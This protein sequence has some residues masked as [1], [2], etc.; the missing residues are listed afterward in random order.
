MPSQAL[1]W[2]DGLFKFN[3]VRT[4]DREGERKPANRCSDRI[5]QQ[6]CHVNRLAGA[7]NTAFSIGKNIE[8]AGRGAALYSTI[9]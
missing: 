4:H 1:I 7:I 2:N 5:A 6:A 9:S 3:A 8:G